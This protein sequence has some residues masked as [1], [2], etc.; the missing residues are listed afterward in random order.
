MRAAAVKWRE[1]HAAEHNLW[2]IKTVKHLA[3]VNAAG[4][5]GAAALY[6]SA[7][8][9]RKATGLFGIPSTVFFAL[10]L[11]LAVLDMYLNSLGALARI[12]EMDGRIRL[13]DQQRDQQQAHAEALLAP[14]TAGRRHFNW[15]GRTGWGSA[16]L[17]CAGALPF[18]LLRL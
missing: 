18:A 3:F 1:N 11:V 4:L 13:W 16:I 15:A 6:T 12:H 5:A 2:T 14:S 17:F 7:D 8:L 10:G 9:A